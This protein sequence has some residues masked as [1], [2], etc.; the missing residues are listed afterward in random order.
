MRA[1]QAR[2]DAFRHEY[3]EQRPH[4]ALQQRPP[5]KLYVTSRRAFPERIEEPEYPSWYEVLSPLTA[6]YVWF[7]G[8][9]Y[10]IST[11]LHGERVGLVEVEDGCHAVYF[12]NHLLGHIHTAHPDLGLI[13]A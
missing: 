7:R 2:F 5:A 9:Q 4:E 12:C 3:N 10:F 13:A 1:Q 11:A 8:N 6:G